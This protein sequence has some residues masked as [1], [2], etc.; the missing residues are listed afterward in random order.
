MEIGFSSSQSFSISDRIMFYRILL[1]NI[2]NHDQW[3]SF[4]SF[5]HMVNIHI[6][7]TST[8]HSTLINILDTPPLHHQILTTM[9]NTISPWVPK[10]N[11]GS[12]DKSDLH[13][14]TKLSAG[15]IN[16]PPA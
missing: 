1:Q 4:H 7:K 11:R 12:E 14:A 13:M 5:T 3:I 16:D 8:Q 10:V 2:H 6:I 15:F 9:Q